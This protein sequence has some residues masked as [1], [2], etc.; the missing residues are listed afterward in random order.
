MRSGSKK[1]DGNGTWKDDDDDDDND[2]VGGGDSLG[3]GAD[4]GTIFLLFLRSDI[5]FFPTNDVWSLDPDK[6]EVLYEISSA[7]PMMMMIMM[8]MMMITT[9]MMTMDLDKIEVLFEK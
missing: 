2:V 5:R 1:Q 7:S 8:V 4:V 9:M 6:I 3:G